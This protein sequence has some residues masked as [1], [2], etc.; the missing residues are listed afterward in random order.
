MNIVISEQRSGKRHEKNFWTAAAAARRPR[1]VNVLLN[2]QSSLLLVAS[3]SLASSP[4][5][6]ECLLKTAE[7]VCSRVG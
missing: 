1:T 4:A 3:P 7:D 6:P 5:K 2:S